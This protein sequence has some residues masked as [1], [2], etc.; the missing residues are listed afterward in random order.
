MQ[1]HTLLS[2]QMVSQLNIAFPYSIG[3]FTLNMQRESSTHNQVIH[4]K[5]I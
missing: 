3:S 5:N 2:K 1:R 4:Q